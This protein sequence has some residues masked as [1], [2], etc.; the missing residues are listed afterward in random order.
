MHLEDA[1]LY[2]VLDS[3]LIPYFTSKEQAILCIVAFLDPSG[4]TSPSSL[5]A[6]TVGKENLKEL[7]G[8]K[9]NN[10]YVE[11]SNGIHFKN[12]TQSLQCVIGLEMFTLNEVTGRM[13]TA[14]LLHEIGHNFFREY[15]LFYY[16]SKVIFITDI[17]NVLNRDIKKIKHN[18]VDSETIMN[19][20][21]T[22]NI[23]SSNIRYIFTKLINAYKK[24]PFYPIVMQLLSILNTIK[25]FIDSANA[26]ISR[27]QHINIFK[28]ITTAIDYK[29]KDL[30]T[31]E[32]I[33]RIPG[34]IVG[35]RN[36]QFADNFATAYGYGKETVEIQRVFANGN[37][38]LF[39]S[40]LNSNVITG[41][42][43][44]ALNTIDRITFY[45]EDVHPESVSRAI[46]QLNYL[47]ENLNN[48]DK[49]T[50]KKI[51]SDI[52]EC[53]KALNEFKNSI[54]I[55]ESAK[56]GKLFSAI[57]NNIIFA[58]NGDLRYHLQKNI[59]GK[60]AGRHSGKYR[61]Q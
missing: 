42:I 22:G 38:S 58:T 29:I 9:K 7:I 17:I 55:K 54:T 57:Y 44:D 56:H 37:M 16:M 53:E 26:F 32:G 60:N 39:N 33:K 48:Y 40:L 41:T 21:M 35:Y 50:T 34:N 4:I 1:S 19:F 27:L 45:G 30:S 13:I 11:D 47:K 2:L 25:D 31:V 8:F 10:P 23:F 3:S 28:N 52:D 51:L 61:L 46:D 59:K 36:E 49:K 18:I 20:V 24:T 12:K 15:S 14:V 6:F 5:N 43:C